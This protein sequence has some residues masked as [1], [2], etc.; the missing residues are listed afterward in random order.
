KRTR[1]DV[2]EQLRKIDIITNYVPCD[3]LKEQ[4][5]KINEIK[6][7]IAIKKKLYN[8]ENYIL[9][10]FQKIRLVLDDANYDDPN[11]PM[12]SSKTDKLIELISKNI[13]SKIIVFTSY[14]M[15]LDKLL[16]FLQSKGIKAIKVS[17]DMSKE[18]RNEKI[19]EYKTSKDTNVL[20]SSDILAYGINLETSTV[21]IHYDLPLLGGKL[22][23]RI[24][25]MVRATSQTS[26]VYN[27]IL[28]TNTQFDT[29]VKEILLRKIAYAEAVT[30]ETSSVESLGF[31]KKDILSVM[32][33][34]L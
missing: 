34:V 14:K 1:E 32:K 15:I 24:Y 4:E 8:N 31:T 16:I 13:G 29:H 10:Y 28:T 21:M 7:E 18:E 6:Q 30:K 20:I 2:G 23:Q 19:K 12:I 17:S 9:E 22:K 25:R 27:Y 26:V 11:K 33:K 5:R 3:L